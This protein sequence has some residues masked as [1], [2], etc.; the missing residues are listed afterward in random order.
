MPLSTLPS[1][2]V[3][4]LSSLRRP[5][6]AL[7]VSFVQKIQPKLGVVVLAVT[8]PVTSAGGQTFSLS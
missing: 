3:I 8:L 2:V 6:V 5:A 7:A 1:P 4:A